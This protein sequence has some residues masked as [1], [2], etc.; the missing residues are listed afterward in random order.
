MG[1]MPLLVFMYGAEA[2]NLYHQLWLCYLVS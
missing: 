1:V 2:L